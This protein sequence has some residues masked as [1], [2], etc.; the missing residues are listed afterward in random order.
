MAVTSQIDGMPIAFDGMAWRY[1]E[2]G[3]LVEKFSEDGTLCQG[4]GRIYVMD[5]IVPDDLWE[6]VKPPQKPKGAGLLCP[7]C[8]VS[9]LEQQL[10][11][12][13][14]ALEKR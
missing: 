11:F 12:C 7:Q 9:R 6:S 10:G 8:I 5:L 13:T 1:V 2:T 14:F 3:C 4:C